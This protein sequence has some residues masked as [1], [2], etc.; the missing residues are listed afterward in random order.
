[1]NMNND[2]VGNLVH[3]QNWESCGASARERQAT[4]NITNLFT[5]RSMSMNCEGCRASSRARRAAAAV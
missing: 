1:M 2:A 3:E 5:M 4:T